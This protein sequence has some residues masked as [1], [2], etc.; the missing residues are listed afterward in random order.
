[1]KKD[2]N[3]IGII[4]IILLLIV[5]TIIPNYCYAKDTLGLGDLNEYEGTSPGSDKLVNKAN[6]LVSSIRVIGVILSVVILIIIGIKYMLGSVE[7]KA[8]YKNTLL[9]Y[10]IGAFL[11]FTGSLI[12]QIIYDIVQKNF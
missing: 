8:E 9:P 4:L 11:V 12:P 1:M 5:L 3:I 7:E 10:L 2:R 6:I